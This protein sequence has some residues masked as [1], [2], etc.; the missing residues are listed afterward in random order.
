LRGII[1][2]M[3]EML[4]M[5]ADRIKVRPSRNEPT[6]YAMTRALIRLLPILATAA[7][8]A[9]CAPPM[10]YDNPDIKADYTIGN[11]LFDV[12]AVET[13]DGYDVYVA[14]LGG[15]H[16]LDFIMLDTAT[17]VEAAENVLGDHCERAVLDNNWRTFGFD[18]FPQ[19]SLGIVAS[20]SCS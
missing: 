5:G 12:R 17:H 6:G 19:P 10:G 14:E 13:T 20:F 3:R 8:V 15:P 11:H 1:R 2:L 4:D 16:R 9:A 18:G 7:G